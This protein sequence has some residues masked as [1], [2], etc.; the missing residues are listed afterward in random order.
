MSSDES[1][2]KPDLSDIALEA[3]AASTK[4]PNDPGRSFSS[5]KLGV[6]DPEMLNLIFAHRFA[7][8]EY[9]DKELTEALYSPQ[10]LVFRSVKD[11]FYVIDMRT[12]DGEVHPTLVPMS[13]F[14]KRN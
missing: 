2:P 3:A 11:G 10:T 8:F 12:S 14:T 1:F 6:M 7:G 9:S 13:V 4:D 5:L